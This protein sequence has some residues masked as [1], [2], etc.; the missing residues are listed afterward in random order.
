MATFVKEVLK[1]IA[2]EILEGDWKK[3]SS[4]KLFLHSLSFVKYRS[5]Y[6]I[7]STQKTNAEEAYNNPIYN[8]AGILGAIW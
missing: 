4:V 8:I 7:A 2:C 1:F 3:I 6:N 5:A